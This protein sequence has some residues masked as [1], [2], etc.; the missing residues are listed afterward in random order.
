MDKCFGRQKIPKLTQEERDN[1]HS[2][3][4]IQ[5]IDFVIKKLTTKKILGSDDLVN[6]TKLKGRNDIKSIKTL[7]E[8]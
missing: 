7:P 4:Y 8:N 3:E 2:P 6:S 5:E 1:L